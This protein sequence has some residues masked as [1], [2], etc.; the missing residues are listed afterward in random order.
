MKFPIALILLILSTISFT[1]TANDNIGVG[2]QFFAESG[3]NDV[4]ISGG[5]IIIGGEDD[6]H[7]TYAYF[8]LGF[9]VIEGF[10][11]DIDGS[12]PQMIMGFALPWKISP[13]VE[14]GFDPVDMVVEEFDEN[15]DGI[16]AYFGLGARFSLNQRLALDLGYKYHHFSNDFDNFTL[17][18]HHHHGERYENNIG[19][20]SVSLNFSF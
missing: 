6:R 19:T 3:E 8:G 18:D 2:F 4:Q 12:Y 5:N 14:V 1:T 20:A 10:S 11:D 17:Y 9:K 15:E 7:E 16:N 13:Y